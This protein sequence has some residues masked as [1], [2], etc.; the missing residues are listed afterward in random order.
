MTA[1]NT[2][3]LDGKTIVVT[4]AGRGQGAAEAAALLEA[5]ATVVACDLAWQDTDPAV[6]DR[7]RLLRRE[8]DV[9]DPTA[10]PTLTEELAQRG[11][12]IVHGLVNNAGVTHRARL[13]DVELEDWNRVFAVNVSGPLLGIQALMPLMT[14]GGSIINVGSLAAVTAHA[15]V[16]YTSSKWAL[17]GLTHTASMQL[18]PR[19]IRVNLLNPGYIETPM[20]GAAPDSFRRANLANTPISR[21]G[22]VGD[23]VPLVVFLLS[24]AAAFIT[25]AEIPVDGGQAAHGG[26]KYIYD[27]EAMEARTGAGR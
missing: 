26:A 7:D 20:T 14:D 16:S 2:P 17:R 18:G 5:G 15:A 25:G 3:V 1:A 23:I 12:G 24:D 9:S 6:A 4:G 8:L 19:A 11:D 22:A 21:L 13:G 27:F 10:W